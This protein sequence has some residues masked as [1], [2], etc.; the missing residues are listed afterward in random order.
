MTFH[1]WRDYFSSMF[2]D[3]V[4]SEYRHQQQPIKRLLPSK[5]ERKAQLCSSGLTHGML[6]DPPLRLP[7]FC[8]PLPTL[9]RFL[10]CVGMRPS[11]QQSIFEIVT[12]TEERTTFPTRRPYGVSNRT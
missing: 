10:L 6:S 5:I 4:I 11:I 2:V 9:L 7:H 3:N 1:Q 8:R 12:S